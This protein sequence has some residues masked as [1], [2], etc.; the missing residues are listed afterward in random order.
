MKLKLFVIFLTVITTILSLF[1]GFKAFSN[2]V[3]EKAYTYGIYYILIINILL[4]LFAL[5]RSHNNFNF[6]NYWKNHKI[7]IILALILVCLGS[8]I[9]KPDFR[10]LADETNLL[11]MSQALYENRECKN[12]TS[13]SYFYYGF[14][15]IIRYE[16]DKRPALFPLTVSFVHSLTG[17]RPENIFITNIIVAFFSLLFLYHLINYKFDKFWGICSMLL[18]ASYPLFILY[19]NSGG[20]EVFNLLFSLILFL[21]LLKFIKEPTAVNTEALLLFLPLIS[22]TRYESVT[23]VICILPVIFFMLKKSEY[24]N[25]G[26]KLV[27]VPLF[28]IPIAWLRLLTDNVRGFQAEDKEAAFSFKLFK[29]NL[30][31]AFPFFC[32]QDFTFGIN[33]VIT[34]TA[35]IGLIWIILE[36]LIELINMKK[37]F[38]RKDFSQNN[39]FT[40]NK[41]VFIFSVVMFYFF[42]AVIRFAFW[43]G[44]LPLRSQSRLAIIFLP[45][46]VYFSIYLFNAISLKL[47]IRKNYFLLFIISFLF[48]YWPVAGQNLGVRDL[49]LYREFR[50]AREFLSKNFPNKN[51]YI[52]VANRS[53]LYVPLKYS[54]IN[55]EYLRNNLLSIK[56]DLSNKTYR[57]LLLIQTINKLRNKPINECIAP[58]E[59]ELECLYETQ[60]RADQFLRISKCVLDL[61]KDNSK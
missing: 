54:S 48:I 51:D 41:I 38:E 28:F 13:I 59:L 50:A 17:Y 14:K 61:N 39:I 32:G 7:A 11:S 18:L 57:Y 26:Y 58:N 3:M 30:G 2:D 35:I 15:N 56:N 1:L 45:V 16:F 43:G 60:I 55:F 12:Y 22:Q 23:A 53:N 52:V 9:S 25:F 33:Q 19:Y 20:F 4:W 46:F 29:E 10:I 42:H 24:L 21:L 47:S 34:Y 49:V 6:S 37:S 36:F 8:F 31:K 27:L 44:D 5:I 40:K